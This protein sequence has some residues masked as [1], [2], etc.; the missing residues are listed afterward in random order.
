MD[1]IK[2]RKPFWK[3]PYMLVL[4]ALIF[5]LIFW[6]G[7][8]FSAVKE[9]FTSVDGG[10]SFET[11]FFLFEDDKFLPALGNTLLFAIVSIVLQFLLALALALFINRNFKG[12]SFFLFLMM[13]PM[14]IP[15][16][17]VGIIWDTGLT[18]SGWFNS[19]LSV[20]GIQWFLDTIGITDG[21]ILWKG[22]TGFKAIMLLVL[23]DTW[24]VLP[25]VM[26][27]ILAGLQNLNKEYSEAALVF[28]ATRFQTVKHII[29]PIIKPTI[30]TALLLRIISGVQVWLI[31][32]MVFDFDTVPFLVERIVYYNK[33]FYTDEYFKLSVAYSIF[34]MMLVMTIATIFLS[35]NKKAERGRT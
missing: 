34:V 13:I 9:V 19:I 1:K 24:T 17:A 33:F 12:S 25:S 10:F 23:I 6:A 27:I 26:I 22:A 16:A 18:E 29:V 8:V 31:A 15:I 28:G 21:A 7:P 5:Y 14:A 20:T 35:A 30:I 3:S 2:T 11:I 32:V 4:P